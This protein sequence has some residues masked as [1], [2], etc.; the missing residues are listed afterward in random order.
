MEYSREGSKVDVANPSEAVLGIRPCNVPVWEHQSS[1]LW[2]YSVPGWERLASGARR[3]PEL[4]GGRVV[5]L[6]LFGVK[7][8]GTAPTAPEGAG[9]SELLLLDERRDSSASLR[10]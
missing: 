7:A 8:Q 6:S 10:E 1:A 4:T 2:A 3:E 9:G 5:A